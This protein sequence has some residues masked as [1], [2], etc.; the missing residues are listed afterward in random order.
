M[1]LFESRQADAATVYAFGV[2]LAL[3]LVL[4]VAAGTLFWF[5]CGG[6]GGDG[7]GPTDEELAAEYTAAGWTAFEAGDFEEAEGHFSD[8]L[9][10]VETYAPAHLGFGWC[11]ALGGDY[12]GASTSFD[13]AIANGLSGADPYAGKAAA[14]RDIV[15]ADHAGAIEAAT[16]ALGAAPTYQFSHDASFDWRDL[17]LILAQASFALGDYAT[18]NDHLP[19]LGAAALNESSDTFVEDLLAELEDLGTTIGG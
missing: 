1:K 6:G 9:E 14:L 19:P 2:V 18:A 17:M 13:A 10:K 5:G 7:N 12:A 15:P 3:A 4:V 16:L 11:R 8:A